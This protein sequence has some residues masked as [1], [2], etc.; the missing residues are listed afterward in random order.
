MII[1]F[2][3]DFFLYYG[4]GKRDD[5][6]LKM[7]KW[8]IKDLTG[9]GDVEL[10]LDDS[11]RVFVLFGS[12]GVGKTKI[13]EAINFIYSRCYGNE[14]HNFRFDDEYSHCFCGRINLLSNYSLF[15]KLTHN[16]NHF[17]ISDS[18]VAIDECT[19]DN[20]IVNTFPQSCFINSSDRSYIVDRTEYSSEY[21]SEDLSDTLD[22]N[23]S[24]WIISKAQSVNPY[25]KQS[26]KRKNEIE[27][28]LEAL[29][30][31]DSRIKKNLS[32]DDNKVYLQIDE[33]ERELSQ[34]SSG[35]RS[36]IKIIQS[37]ISAYSRNST[38][39]VENLFEVKGVVLID[40]IENHLHLEWQVKIIPTL[41]KL[42]PNTTFY[43]A[44]H[45]PL[46]LSQL[47]EGEAYLL[48]RDDD[49]VVR[50]K[51]VNSP[52][53]R[54]LANVLSDTFGIDLNQLKRQSMEHSDQSKAKA[55][56]LAL[57]KDKKNKE[58]YFS[59]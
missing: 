9:V 6:G 13:L 27:Y 32:I 54:I 58:G 39:D 51:M 25:H 22:L 19:Y 11:K 56:L 30:I 16:D 34:L 2:L 1:S 12:N 59:E 18:L 24:G 55:K 31:L 35:F 40:E 42:F 29:N 38:D 15:S 45:S 10:S 37:I 17:S 46:V 47:E 57:L 8:Q 23:I 33:K 49:G 21:N 41:K 3:G 50:S 36:V 48:Q 7:N 43:I 53:K 4:V 44:T 52:N 14:K 28:F 26:Q 5:K 20:V